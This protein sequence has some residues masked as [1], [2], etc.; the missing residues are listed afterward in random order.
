M[1]TLF[2]AAIFMLPLFSLA[3]AKVSVPEG[4]YVFALTKEYGSIRQLE[5]T[6]R[7]E[8]R[9]GIDTLVVDVVGNLEKGKVED[10]DIACEANSDSSEIKCERNDGGGDFTLLKSKTITGSSHKYSLKLIYFAF[11]E[12]GD[13][14]PVAISSPNVE[15]PIEIPGTKEDK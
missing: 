9:E 13:E 7:S 8:D 2:I 5:I 10:G 6:F 15:K 3:Q 1:K 12:E 14:N 4:R 11:G